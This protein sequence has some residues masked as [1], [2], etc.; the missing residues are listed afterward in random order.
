MPARTQGL[1]ES[2]LSG[3][4]ELSSSTSLSMGGFIRSV[5]YLGQTPEE[6]V[7]YFQ[8]AYAQ[9]GLLMSVKSGAWATAKTDI[10][11]RYG[12]EFQEAVTELDIREAYVDLSGGPACLRFGKLISPW[13]KGTLFNPTDKI[14]PINPIVRS[15]DSEDLQIGS[16]ALQG[17]INLGSYMKITGTWKPLYQASQL[18]I[19]PVPM[20]AYVVFQE[21]EFPGAEL[22]EGSYGIRYDLHLPLLDAS[23][24]GFSGYHPWPGISYQSF[25]IDLQTLE[26]RSLNLRQKAYEIY[27]VG[28]DLSVPVGSWILR[29]ESA[30]QQSQDE[31]SEREY[32]PLPELA[33]TAEIERSGSYITLLAGYYGKYIMDFTP[34][35]APP[36]LSPSQDQ[37]TDLLQK[38]L[39]LTPELIESAVSEQIGAFN[40]LYNYQLDEFHH[41]AFAVCE[42]RF[43]HDRLEFRI[44]LIYHITTEEWM[45]QPR[46]SYLPS[47]G[48]RIS[49]GFS[50]L[51]GPENSLYDLAGPVLNAG[52]LSLRLLF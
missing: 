24:Y 12:V 25:Q 19:E 2:S 46:I 14:T 30:W 17:S 9:T 18:L 22:N 11:F 45:I 3:D 27:M 42:G 37:F 38:G 49:T 29:M 48:I 51:Y 31:H 43:W 4:Q 23:L 36:S 44:P 34:P 15:P 1:F 35:S 20:P 16:W 13:G 40:R 26:P 47:D 28:M 8:S 7:P 33:Y 10:R 5:A 6:E 50:G 39:L 32:L 41:A 52:Y 21:P